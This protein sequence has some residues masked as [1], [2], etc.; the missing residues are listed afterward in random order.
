MLAAMV[1]LCALSPVDDAAVE[2]ALGSA[3]PNEV[4]LRAAW[5]SCPEPLRG[6]L[7][8]LLLNMP[9]RDLRTLSG[10]RLLENVALAPEAL[11]RAPWRDRVPESVFRNAVLP[12]AHV[13]EA[14]DDWRR[15][16][17]DRYQSKALE[18]GDPLRVALW[19]NENLFAD[20]GVK[21]HP[22]KRRAPDQ[23]VTETLR[24]RYASCTGLSILLANALRSV[25]VPARLVGV[26]QWHDRSGN[27]TWVEV[28]DGERWRSLGAAEPGPP[29]QTWFREKAARAN[30]AKRESAVWAVWFERGKH[31]FP[32][33][34][35]KDAWD[36][37][38]VNVTREYQRS[39]ARELRLAPEPQEFEPL[40][41]SFVAEAGAVVS[42]E[43]GE[44]A[45]RLARS[46][47]D[48]LGASLGKAGAIR[49]LEERADRAF[50]HVEIRVESVL[51]RFAGEA[52]SETAL[53]W[54]RALRS[55]PESGGPFVKLP[56]CRIRSGG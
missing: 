11:E 51:V 43:G 27:H 48:L 55:L 46:V 12:Y 37:P 6:D 4:S 1:L 24:L 18:I 30:A 33:S 21:Y 9:V 49:V 17:R 40:E 54:L 42:F 14:R 38:A 28:W 52:G 23:C 50:A 29:D 47:A 15:L 16:L 19:M 36:I 32:V 26:Y 56:C 20:F 44:T 45:Q 8:F 39:F 25:A 2:A 41:G 5:R 3:G 31:T 7:R 34:W 22:T 35:R 53:A 10:E 13:T